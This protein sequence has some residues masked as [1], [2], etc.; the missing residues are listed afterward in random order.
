V[1]S[2]TAV[3]PPTVAP[4]LKPTETQAAPAAPT[5]PPTFTPTPLS[6]PTS[7]PEATATPTPAP[8]QPPAL[9]PAAENGLAAWC[10]PEGYALSYAS[11]PFAPPADARIGAIEKGALEIHNLPVSAC[12]II[13]TFNQ[14]APA[15]L[16]LQIFDQLN[17]Q[18]W[19]TADL[20]P[21]KDK[22][23]SVAAV[24]RHTYIVA[25]PVWGVSY[26]F[27]VVD[28]AGKEVRRDPVN[29]HRW[30]PKLCWNGQPPN[31]LTLRC[32]LPQDLHPWDPSY[33]T[34][35]PTFPAPGD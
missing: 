6:S 34:P 30:T 16:K 14:P 18:P 15:G 3:V 1:A 19:W 10:L 29:L 5:L 9:A 13:Y 27:A 24:L 26:T 17:K 33:G 20:L 11:D 7:A 28:A 22:P 25:P 4:V 23:E 21:V 2:A 12:V 35:I 32:P 8:T 31:V